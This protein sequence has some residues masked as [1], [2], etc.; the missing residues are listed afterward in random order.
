MKWNEKPQEI[1]DFWNSNIRM[2]EGYEKEF[3]WQNKRIKYSITYRDKKK[4][5]TVFEYEFDGVKP[6]GNTNHQ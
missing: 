3:D 4:P 1:T 2:I 5:Y 6:I